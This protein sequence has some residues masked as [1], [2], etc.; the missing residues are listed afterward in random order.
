MSALH[1]ELIAPDRAEI[2]KSMGHIMVLSRK[3]LQQVG[4]DYKTMRR[5]L[6]NMGLV[7]NESKY[8]LTIASAEFQL[9]FL[10][11]ELYH[12]DVLHNFSPCVPEE[13]KTIFLCWL[14][15]RYTNWLSDIN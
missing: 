6:K 7:M 2:E 13:E 3:E 10:M 12:L 14:K 8:E 9:R 1:N 5:E 11:G 15:N 4:V